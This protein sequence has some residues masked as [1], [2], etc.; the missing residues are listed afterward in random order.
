MPTEF[1]ERCCRIAA[2]QHGST[3]STSRDH[4]RAPPSKTPSAR[5][6]RFTL[7]LLSDSTNKEESNTDAG[8]EE[9]DNTEKY[10]GPD[11]I[12]DPSIR[13]DNKVGKR[14]IIVTRAEQNGHSLK[15]KP[16][17]R[18][19]TR[20][21]K[22]HRSFKIRQYLV[23]RLHIRM[24]RAYLCPPVGSSI[25][26]DITP[27]Q[28]GTELADTKALE[29]FKPIFPCTTEQP[30]H[31][32]FN[33]YPPGIPLD[34]E[35]SSLRYFNGTDM[36]S[37]MPFPSYDPDHAPN[38]SWNDIESLQTILPGQRSFQTHM[39][40]ASLTQE[41]FTKNRFLNCLDVQTMSQPL[42]AAYELCLPRFH[43]DLPIR[44]VNETGV[45]S[46]Q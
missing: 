35:S 11:M 45:W 31:S 36:S 17:K 40:R 22:G 41:P 44:R 46:A 25:V 20:S 42:D 3:S 2:E 23:F 12:R 43:G 6:E 8:D 13:V 29:S 38:P 15:T 26:Q 19:N 4:K 5:Q 37:E 27:S 24:V 18:R 32:A 34:D 30:A 28:P 21:V 16:R 33:S 9:S 10:V 7:D 14:I 39:D 1:R